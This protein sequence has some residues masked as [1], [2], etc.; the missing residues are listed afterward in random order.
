MTLFNTLLL[1]SY[2]N[3]GICYFITNLLIYK[4]INDIEKS[5]GSIQSRRNNRK[6]N[7]NKPT[8]YYYKKQIYMSVLWPIT[9][10]IVL[11]DVLKIG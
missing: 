2:I 7:K 9:I 1:L 4:S 5:V 10:F 11:K 3:I 6:N 8:A